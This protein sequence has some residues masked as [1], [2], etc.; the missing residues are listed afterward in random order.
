MPEQTDG[1]RIRKVLLEVVAEYSRQGSGMFQSGIVVGE[2]AQRLGFTRDVS[3]QQA[4]LTAWDDLFRTGYLGWG[5]D[6]SNLA[7]P[8][9][10][11]TEQGREVLKHLS[12]D[13]SNPTGYWAHMDS[14]GA[15][16]PVARS[17][18][19]EALLTFNAGCVKATAV[20]TGAAS[21]RII[22]DLSDSLARKLSSLSVKPNR[23]L[24]DWRIKRVI[25]ALRG[26]LDAKKAGMPRDLQ[27]EYEAYWPAFTQ[28]IRAARNEAGHPTSIEPVTYDTVHAS[29]LIFPELARLAARLDNWI[30]TS[31]S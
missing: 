16:S 9:L 6:I 15:L 17:Y 27:E 28:Q 12:R 30:S 5:H 22:L 4:L 10:H 7:P 25:E 26:Y 20:M 21:E 18:L 1:H 11:L 2:A 23:D 19:S 24:Q 13:P 29:L 14:V 8:F 31:L 3:L